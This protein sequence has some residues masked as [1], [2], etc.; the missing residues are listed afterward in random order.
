MS[1]KIQ[2]A[3]V[4]CGYWGP[5]LI[6]N[7]RSLKT[8]AVR[9][10]CDRDEAS[11]R[12][13]EDMYPEL[14]T[15]SEFD[16]VLADSQ[17]DA[18]AIATPAHTHYA[19]AKAA[20]LAG[21]HT[22]IEKPMATRADDC[23]ELI[24]I[25]DRVDCKLM[26]GHTF[27]YSAPVQLIKEIVDSGELGD[28]LYVS[29]QRLNLGLF[30]NDINVTWDLAPH[31]LSIV[32]H[33]LGNKP[34]SVNCQGRAHVNP[35]VADV[36]NMSLAFPRGQFAMVQTSWLDPVKVRRITVVGSKKMILYDDTAPL[37][38][39]KIFDKRVEVPPHYATYAEFHYSYHYGDMRVPYL[40]QSEPL[41]NECQDFLEAIQQDRPPLV[42]GED[43]L[44]VVEILEAAET[45]LNAGGQQVQLRGIHDYRADKAPLQA[46]V[47]PFNSTGNIGAIG[48]PGN[49]ATH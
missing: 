43:G 7:F 19:L 21:K 30:Q 36:T 8:C 39:V 37:E 11:R 27:I 17:I 4:G 44:R 40:N 16:D 6:R 46:A 45:S 28:V 34:E 1:K 24:E 3:V 32:L 18:V 33:L 26:V 12:R 5:N 9:L 14:A 13:I 10:V 38:K 2:V 15:T 31:D 42:T 25:A 29:A 41:R 20:L 22:L 47:P 48:L 35:E 23:R 49:L